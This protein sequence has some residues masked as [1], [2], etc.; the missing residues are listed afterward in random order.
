MGVS[1]R[2]PSGLPR[3]FVRITW[4]STLRIVEKIRKR[5]RVYEEE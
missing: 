3:F 5:K 4:S 1:S 2:T